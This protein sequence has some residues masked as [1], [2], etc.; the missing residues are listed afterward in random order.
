MRVLS[1]C[2]A[3]TLLGGL[4]S[5]ADSPPAQIRDIHWKYIR[6]PQFL[7]PG[8]T[9]KKMEVMVSCGENQDTPKPQY[10][11]FDIIWKG[12]PRAQPPSALADRKKIVVRLHLPDATVESKTF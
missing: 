7:V 8:E 11:R 9:E 2:V 12:P 5:A 1:L 6:Y 4:V 10:L 3:L